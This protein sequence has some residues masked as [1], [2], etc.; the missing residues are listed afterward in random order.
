M[1]KKIVGIFILMLFVGANAISALSNDF[2]SI[3][4][5]LLTS[6]SSNVEWTNTYG[7]DR[8]EMLQC[9]HQTNDNGYIACG[10]KQAYDTEQKVYRPWVIKT[11]SSGNLEWE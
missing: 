5:S 3:E 4:D 10:L 9:V 7:D 11:D 1:N 6:K 8:F 2:L